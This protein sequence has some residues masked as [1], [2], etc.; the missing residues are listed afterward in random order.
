[1]KF[2]WI[3]HKEDTSNVINGIN[4]ANTTNVPTCHCAN[5]DALYVVVVKVH[6][7]IGDVT[8]QV[9]GSGRQVL[10]VVKVQ[11][12]VAEVDQSRERT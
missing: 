2:I 7:R 9:D 4:G 10:Y 6:L 1:M 3:S 11:P 8:V 12:D 5:L